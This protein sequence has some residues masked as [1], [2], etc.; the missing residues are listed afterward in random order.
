M[1]A[2]GG[3]SGLAAVAATEYDPR[4]RLIVVIVIKF[5]GPWSI[6]AV[7]K[8]GDESYAASTS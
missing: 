5:S 6:G 4:L 3:Y 1:R 2:E 8:A 7:L